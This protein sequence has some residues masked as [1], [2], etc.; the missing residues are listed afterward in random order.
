MR[1]I[2]ALLESRSALTAL[3]R[4]FPRGSP[5][6]MGCRSPAGLERV[7]ATRLVEAIVVGL[8]PA[9]S[10]AVRALRARF[11]RVPLVL[12]APVRSE[13]APVL[14]ALLPAGLAA[15]AVEGVD[16]AITGELILRVSASQRRRDALADAPR[17]LRLREPLQQRAWELLA[18]SFDRPP[19]TA[20]LARA[21][22]CS[23]EHLSRQFAAGGAPN[24][25]RVSDFLAVHAALTLLG[26]PGYSPSI[27]AGL[28]GFGG[29]GRLQQ[30]VRRITG[31]GLPAAQ[32]AGERDALARFLR[33]STRSRPVR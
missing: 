25:K 14:L 9:R 10:E 2:A 8:G 15:L 3:R 17:V 31:L 23:R 21:L 26:N 19:P 20:T 22:R 6:V 33:T 1:A 13:D 12:F 28:L 29:R 7:L 11:P 5:P 4:S 16:D 27:V 24:L 32:A 30:V 18:G